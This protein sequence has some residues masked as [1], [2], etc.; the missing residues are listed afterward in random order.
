MLDVKELFYGRKA[1]KNAL[2][3]FGFR[4]QGGVYLYS[5]E[6]AGGQFTLTVRIAGD[7]VS[8]EVYDREAESPY[9]LFRVEGA[10]GQFVGE[11]RAEYE[12]TLE[13]ISDKCF[14]R[15]EIYREKVT[16]G[17]LKYG[18]KKYATPP[19]FL[20]HD[21]NCVMRRRD[22][23]KWYVLIMVVPRARL[24]LGGEGKIEVAN[25]MA[26]VDEIPKLI[27]GKNFLPAYHMNKKSWFTVLLD[28]R[29]SGEVVCALADVSYGLASKRR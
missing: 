29:V 16:L 28:G 21:E 22:S 13:E 7:A 24:G 10:E 26:P 1:D 3:K 20:W 9:Y 19:E 23:G 4:E 18:R 5:R 12:G 25:M 27:D 15:A 8:A 6:I 17:L 14:S 2:V 11:V